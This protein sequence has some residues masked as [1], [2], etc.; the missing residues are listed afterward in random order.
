MWGWQRNVSWNG[1]NK[2]G[3]LGFR[4]PVSEIR[5]SL[6][7]EG[8]NISR[9]FG[10]E[11]FF[12]PGIAPEENVCRRVIELRE[13]NVMTLKAARPLELVDQ[14]AEILPTVLGWC[15]TF[16]VTAAFGTA[17]L[18]ISCVQ[19]TNGTINVSATEA[20]AR[21]WRAP[22]H[23][24]RRAAHGC[25]WCCSLLSLRDSWFNFHGLLMYS[26]W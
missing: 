12:Q 4:S 21:V 8:Q 24:L 5:L 13:A 11:D 26:W 20:Q 6:R 10:T 14:W 19:N 15:A 25:G 17:V 1:Y 16:S 23:S 9:C 22:L 2:V 18:T 7:E 3:G